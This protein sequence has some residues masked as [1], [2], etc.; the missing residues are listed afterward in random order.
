MVRVLFAWSLHNLP[1]H[2]CIPSGYSGFLPQPKNLTVNCYFVWLNC[3][4]LSSYHKVWVCA[5]LFVLGFYNNQHHFIFTTADG[6]VASLKQI[7]K[8]PNLLHSFDCH[9]CQRMPTQ[10]YVAQSYRNTWLWAAVF[11]NQ[12]LQNS[13][14]NQ[15]DRVY[16]SGVTEGRSG[17]ST[18]FNHQFVRRPLAFVFNIFLGLS[19]K[20]ICT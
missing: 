1:V 19:R 2:E 16:L 5:W 7:Q 3:P 20:I 6:V 13:F 9:T 18:Y 12:M 10:F 14:S 4:K 17:A 15:H 8:I 11:V